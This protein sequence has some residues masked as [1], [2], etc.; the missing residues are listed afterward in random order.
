MAARLACGG[1]PRYR[2]A[3][4][5][6]SMRR[7]DLPAVVAL[8]ASVH[9]HHPERAEVFAERLA[10][11]PAGCLVLGE[12]VAGY[13]LSHP[14]GLAGPPPLDSLLGTL[15]AA[16]ESWHV[17]DIVVAPAARG[18]G[19]GGAALRALLAVAGGAGFRRASLVAIDGQ[20]PRW[21]RAGFVAATCADA[22][23]L[24]SYGDRAT[25]MTRALVPPQR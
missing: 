5:W 10:L 11:A 16:P 14:W 9:A 8:A 6:R 2:G 18:R 3:M 20:A 17:H 13:A 4:E 7:E 23:A 12:A 15:P 25:W 19:L 1:A 21:A 22:A 24:A